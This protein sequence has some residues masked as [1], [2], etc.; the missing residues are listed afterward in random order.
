MRRSRKEAM[1]AQKETRKEGL[2]YM[3]SVRK[4]GAWKLVRVSTMEMAGNASISR[5]TKPPP[6]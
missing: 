5:W 4:R 1:H 6:D 2:K 3:S